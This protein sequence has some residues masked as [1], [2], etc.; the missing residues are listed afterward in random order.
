MQAIKGTYKDGQVILG[1]PANWPEGTQV[2]VEP[3]PRQ[4]S[5][6]VRE[7]D[8]PAD[9]EGIGR[10]LALMDRIKPLMMKLEEEAAWQAAR[11]D[12]KEFER[13]KLTVEDGAKER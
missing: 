11:K 2:L 13:A 5:L 1:Q 12:Q 10:H 3:I 7:A 8:W 4:H 9:P 6:G